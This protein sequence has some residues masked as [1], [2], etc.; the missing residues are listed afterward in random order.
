M[1]RDTRGCPA[2]AAPSEA[3][4]AIWLIKIQLWIPLRLVE[5]GPQSGA[6][7]MFSGLPKDRLARCT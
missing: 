2:D 7:L 6:F 4:L 1:R 3:A 5:R